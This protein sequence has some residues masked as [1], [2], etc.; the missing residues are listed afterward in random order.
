VG[1]NGEPCRWEGR[2]L[3]EVVDRVQTLGDFGITN[4]NSRTIVEI[5]AKKKSDG[6][7]LHAI[8]GEA[9]LL[10]LKFRVPRNTFKRDVLQQEIPL[11]TLNQSRRS[12]VRL[13]RPSRSPAPCVG[14]SV[15]MPSCL[16]WK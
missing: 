3:Q 9:W 5:A 7:F 10:K 13:S 14:C 16:W 15:S 1:R 12:G 8:T 4:W 2:I 11:P 6:W